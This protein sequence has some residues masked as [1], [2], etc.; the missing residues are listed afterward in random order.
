MTTTD[1]RR[2][3]PVTV[4][5]ATKGTTTHN[6]YAKDAAGARSAAHAFSVA[7]GHIKGERRTVT[8]GDP[9]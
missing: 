3:F 1:P 5:T 2:S 9:A 8:V 6:I 7:Y 4:T